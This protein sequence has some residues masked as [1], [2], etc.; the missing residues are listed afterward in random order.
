LIAIAILLGISNKTFSQSCLTGGSITPAVTYTFN[1]NSQDFS[2]DFIWSGNG[3]GQLESSNFTTVVTTKQLTTATFFLPN[4]ATSIGWSF[5]LSGTANVTSYTVEAL[6]STGSGIASVPV[7]SGGSLTTTGAN[8]VFASP[9]P[10]QIIGTNFRLR[11]TFTSSSNNKMLVV[12]NFRSDAGAALS[13]LPVTISYFSTS[14]AT[15]AIKLTWMVASELNVNRYEIERSAN[16][17]TFSKIGQVAASGLVTYTYLDAA[18]TTGSN[19]YRLKAVDNDGKYKYSTVVLFKVGKNGLAS[20]L[21][22]YPTPATNQLTLWHDAATT[23][24]SISVM[25][26]DGKVVK[27]LKPTAGNTETSID[28]STLQAG[29]YLIRYSVSDMESVTTKLVKQ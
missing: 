4:S 15:G 8:L 14:S 25:T 19:Y 29:L 11:I 10:A 1:T 16:G 23:S 26:V 6:Y 21:K 3:S 27:T 17:K 9:A 28:I 2:G 7:C 5:N 22:I 18:Y 13:P 20:T 24:S 12:D